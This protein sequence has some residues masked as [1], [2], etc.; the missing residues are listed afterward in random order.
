M[1]AHTISARR[2]RRMI[3]FTLNAI[4]SIDAMEPHEKWGTDLATVHGEMALMRDWLLEAAVTDVAIERE[5]ERA[6]IEAK[7]A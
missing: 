5:N 4:A 2:M 7:V 3:R 6:I 1:T